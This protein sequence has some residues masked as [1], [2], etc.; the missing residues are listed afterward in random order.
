MNDLTQSRTAVCVRCDL[1]APIRDEDVVPK[2]WTLI[3]YGDGGPCEDQVS[4]CR[5]CGRAFNAFLD[6]MEFPG[7]MEC[8][9]PGACNCP[10]VFCR[11]HEGG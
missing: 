8:D 10:H 9:P 6:G 3:S 11:Q 4:L 2:G 5:P 7:Q 1:H